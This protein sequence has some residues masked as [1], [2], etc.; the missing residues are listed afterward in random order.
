MAGLDGYFPTL[1]SNLRRS[2]V[3]DWRGYIFLFRLILSF[4]V[5]VE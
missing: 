1:V 4:R 2:I 3:A 5:S